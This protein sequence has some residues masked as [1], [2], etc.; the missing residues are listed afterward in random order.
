MKNIFIKNKITTFV[1]SSLAVGALLSGTTA[2]AQTTT[3]N[4]APQHHEWGRG[5]GMMGKGPGV[6][7]TVTS[8]SGTTLT[9]TQKMML[10]G[11]EN[12]A[13]GT[14]YTVDASS[15]NVMKDGAT[16]SVS[17]IAVGD[18]VTVAGTV[19][20]TSVT[21]T[22]IRDGMLQRGVGQKDPKQPHAQIITGNG[23]PVIGGNVTAISGTTLTVTNKS[24]VVYTVDASSATV[25]KSHATSSVSAIAVG[26]NVIVQGTVQGTSVIASS[27]IDAGIPQTLQSTTGGSEETTSASHQG[28]IGFFGAVG[29]FFHRIFGF[30]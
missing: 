12:N 26:D 13:T 29:G 22:T 1:V 5:G 8:I 17:S 6:F 20:G 24:D 7:G 27:V 10:R 18:V 28:S 21:A 2:F 3:D 16:S 11:G 25:E 30:F 19:N 23:Q 14:V 15:A 4:T 9:V